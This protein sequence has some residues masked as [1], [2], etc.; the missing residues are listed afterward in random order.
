MRALLC[1][2]FGAALLLTTTWC[3]PARTWGQAFRFICQLMVE[4]TT[5]V[6]PRVILNQYAEGLGVTVAEVE[7]G[8]GLDVEIVVDRD[9]TLISE[10]INLGRPAVQLKKSAFDR[11]LTALGSRIAGTED[12]GNER[13][14]FLKNLL[15]P[16]R[17]NGSAA[18]AT[19]AS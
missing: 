9:P 8:L 12:A 14:G 10:S 5:I 7:K 17:S 6:V 4:V 3:D 19:E 18:A 2:Y 1:C 11:S 15:R 16:F 13:A